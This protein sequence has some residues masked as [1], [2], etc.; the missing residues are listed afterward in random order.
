M[1]KNVVA[2]LLFSVFA[3]SEAQAADDPKNMGGY[4]KTVWGMTPDEVLSV[5]APRAEKLKNQIISRPVSG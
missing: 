2:I 1:I 3:A 5:E 4:G